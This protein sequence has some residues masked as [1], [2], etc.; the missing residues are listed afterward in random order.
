MTKRYP[1]KECFLSLQGEGVRAGTVAVFL[2]FAGCNL[3]CKKETVGWDCDTDFSGGDA[4]SLPEV[5]SLVTRT[6]GKSARVPAHSWIV[7]TGG[8]PALFM[9]ADLSVALRISHRLAIETNGTIPLNFAPDWITVSPKPGAPVVVPGADEVKVVLRAGD[10]IPAVDV[11][12]GVHLLSP[13]FEGAVLPEA[14]L[15]H[16]IQLCLENPRWRLS[17]QLHKLVRIR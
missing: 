11:K 2:R 14:N 6:A 12:A 7:L 5:V 4:L 17:V 15:R 3:N 1:I 9:D 13:A 16:C 8:E 10:A